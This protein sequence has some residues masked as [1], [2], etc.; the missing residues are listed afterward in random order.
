[1]NKEG[2]GGVAFYAMLVVLAFLL[3]VCVICP[4]VIPNFSRQPYAVPLM[5][6]GLALPFLHFFIFGGITM[7]QKGG[8]K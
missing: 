4:L 8:K 7:A 6:A 3:V 1:M 2:S 5:G